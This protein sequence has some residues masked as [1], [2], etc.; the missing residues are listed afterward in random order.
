LILVQ[1]NQLLGD[2]DV[3]DL[4]S[5]P[6]SILPAMRN[7]VENYGNAGAAQGAGD[8]HMQ[9]MQGRSSHVQQLGQSFHQEVRRNPIS[10]R[11]K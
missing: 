11:L 4:S 10:H 8:S 1:S 9:A 7:F 2:R 5:A 3:P 6:M